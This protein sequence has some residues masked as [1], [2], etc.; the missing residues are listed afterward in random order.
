MTKAL[1]GGD[2]YYQFEQMYGN[3]SIY[4]YAWNFSRGIG[5]GGNYVLFLWNNPVNFIPVSILGNKLGLD[6]SLIER[7]VFFYPFLMIAF[8]SSY[9]LIRKLFGTSYFNLISP[10][11]FILNTYIV[12]I[13]SG[14]QLQIALAYALAP[15]SL[16]LFIEII[17]SLS[18]ATTKNNENQSIQL[19]KSLLAQSIIAGLVF[20]LQV[21]FDIRI[22]YISLLAILIYFLINIELNLSKISS[23]KILFLMLHVVIIPLGI[24]FLL[25]AFWILPLTTITSNPVEQLGSAFSSIKAVDFFSFAKFENTIS[26]LHPNWPENIFGK[27]YFMRPDFLL[28]PILAFTSSLF[29]SSKNNREKKYIIY[30]TLL[31]LLGAFLGKG[32]ND[33]FGYA[34]LWLFQHIPGFNMYRDPTKWYILVSISFSVLIPYTILNMYR[35]LQ[36]KVEFNIS[37]FVFQVKSKNKVVSLQNLFIL[38]V[39]SYLLFIIR[40]ALLGQLKGTFQS[41][42]VPK[43][44]SNLKDFLHSQPRFFRTL[45]LP[46]NPHFSFYTSLHPA[47]PASN[48]FQKSN[49]TSIP[50]IIQKS[51]TISLLQNSGVKYVV[52]PFD[53]ESEIFLTDRKYDEKKYKEVV[54][55]MDKVASLTKIMGFGKI[56]IYEV[57]SPKDHFWSTQNNLKISYRY[58]N[59]TKYLVTINDGRKGD[60]LIFSESYDPSWTAKIENNN[61]KILSSK[62]DGLYNSFRLPKGG[63]YS[64]EIYYEPQKLVNIGVVISLS[65]L[66]II[67]VSLI[68][69]KLRTKN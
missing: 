20:A 39:I 46:I 33:P 15:F 51:A 13:V 27:T 43:D 22:A 44:Y 6:W 19:R 28:L 1:V 17:N 59:P 53:S 50:P 40:P 9:T 64:L 38:V 3:F 45:W 54:S 26:L 8:A 55:E 23:I 16:L 24:T 7:L 68:Y 2:L 61:S 63:N 60:T 11:I 31:G 52:I 12:M 21:S 14:G 58:I 57:P 32:S 30:F 36:N 69:L 56:I 37:R 48:L 18:F 41:A 34:Y 10:L 25:H 47:I 65:S 49:I 29:T 42:T 35:L 67:L 66:T 5:L 4:P 62:Y